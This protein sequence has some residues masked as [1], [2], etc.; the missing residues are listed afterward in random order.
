MYRPRAEVVILYHFITKAA[1]HLD[2]WCLE[3]IYHLKS[4]MRMFL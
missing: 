3:G 1:A 4:F 2:D